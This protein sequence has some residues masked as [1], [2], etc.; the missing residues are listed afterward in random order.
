MTDVP[1][2]VVADAKAAVSAASADVAKASTELSFVETNWGKLS[3]IVVAAAA[4]GFIVGHI[5]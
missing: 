2:T 4:V 1:A 3:A 5:L